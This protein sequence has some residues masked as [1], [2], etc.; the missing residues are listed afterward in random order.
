MV[1]SL[2]DQDTGEFHSVRRLGT[3]SY[4]KVFVR[5]LIKA[6]LSF[7]SLPTGFINTLQFAPTHTDTHMQPRKDSPLAGFDSTWLD[8]QSQTMN[9]P[10]RKLSVFVIV[11]VHIC[12][13]TGGAA[14]G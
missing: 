9:I 14:S 4:L 8:K 6:R 5:L 3:A 11:S 2:H 1:A 12:P 10:V 13:I 7:S